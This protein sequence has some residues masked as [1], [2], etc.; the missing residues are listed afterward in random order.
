M[1]PLPFLAHFFSSLKP[2]PVR[3]RTA[4]GNTWHVTLWQPECWKLLETLSWNIQEV[5]VPTLESEPRKFMQALLGTKTRT[6]MRNTASEI[7]VPAEYSYS[8]VSN[9]IICNCF[10]IQSYVH[11][12][13]AA[14]KLQISSCFTQLVGLV[15]CFLATMCTMCT[16]HPWIRCHG[17]TQFSKSFVDDFQWK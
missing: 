15:G 16:W 13:F 3:Q 6:T 1:S 2:A 9:Q 5:R 17:Q 7:L 14:S 12:L 10:K 11:S 8:R 4:E